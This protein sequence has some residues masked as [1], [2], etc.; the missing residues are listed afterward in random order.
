M[1]TPVITEEEAL[2]LIND[3]ALIVEGNYMVME[4]D[5]LYIIQRIFGTYTHPFNSTQEELTL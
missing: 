4:S 3:A 1:S 5:A 2:I